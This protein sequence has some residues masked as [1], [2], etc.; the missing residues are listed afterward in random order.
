VPLLN[1]SHGAHW[2]E[3]AENKR[4]SP[5]N[6]GGSGK[7]QQNFAVTR[8]KTKVNGGSIPFDLCSKGIYSSQ[9]SN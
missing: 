8:A 9:Y 7:Y 3:L 6:S 5:K 1:F 4:K 2:E